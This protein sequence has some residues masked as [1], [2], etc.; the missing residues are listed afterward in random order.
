MLLV[1]DFGESGVALDIQTKILKK[2]LKSDEHSD[3]E[4]Q[5]GKGSYPAEEFCIPWDVAFDF[6]FYYSNF[7][8]NA[9]VLYLKD[10]ITQ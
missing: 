2:I 4:E 1:S 5:E 10:R 8:R 9:V 3:E 7:I 6:G